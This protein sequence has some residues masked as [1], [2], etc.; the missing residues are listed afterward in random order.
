MSSAANHTKRSHR[1]QAK[2]YA[3]SGKRAQVSLVKQKKR[4]MNWSHLRGLFSRWTKPRQ[5]RSRKEDAVV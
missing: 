3:A 4:R 2:H 5:R 1:S